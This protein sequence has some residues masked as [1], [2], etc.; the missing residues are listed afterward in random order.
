[1][2]I[3]V[4]LSKKSIG[5]AIRELKKV[6]KW[7]EDGKL[8]KVLLKKI[9]DKLVVLANQKVAESDIGSNIKTRIQLGWKTEITGNKA[10]LR[11]TYEH[12]VYV[13][14]GVGFNGGNTPHEMAE[15]EGWEY[16]IPT[17]AKH[18]GNFWAFKVEST[19]DVDLMSGYIARQSKETGLYYIVTKGSHGVM[20]AYNAIRD[21][22]DTG[23]LQEI[24]K[25]VK[26]EVFGS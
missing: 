2:R 5:K 3:S 8:M 20:Y 15:A 25:E 6:R 16:N 24:W 17:P 9:C 14:F 11:N 21:L 26:R 4:S 23:A 1:M 10:V 18:G 7:F 12:S 19:D 22:V 13:E